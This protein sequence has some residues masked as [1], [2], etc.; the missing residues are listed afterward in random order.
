MQMNKHKRLML[1][2]L[3]ISLSL[4]VVSLPQDLAGQENKPPVTDPSVP[5]PEEP[6]PGPVKPEAGTAEKQ[7]NPATATK[8]IKTFK[9]SET[10]GADSAV[11]FPIDI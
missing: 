7:E 9:P 3:A 4:A 1:I 11:A 8:P 6:Q 2:S 10:I 5:A